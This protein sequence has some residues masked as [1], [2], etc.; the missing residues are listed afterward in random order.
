MLPARS[1][2]NGG[3]MRSFTM[4]SL[5]AVLALVFASSAQAGSI[6]YSL[7]GTWV[8]TFKDKTQSTIAGKAGKS[9]VTYDYNG[10]G[11]KVWINNTDDG[12][13]SAHADTWSWTLT[14]KAGAAELHF[15]NP[16][17]NQDFTVPCVK[18]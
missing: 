14:P 6:P 5:A 2:E 15:Q 3:I 9:G 7:G 16:A 8:C 12:G 10:T 18:Q 1:L 13:I 11:G 4:F 17:K